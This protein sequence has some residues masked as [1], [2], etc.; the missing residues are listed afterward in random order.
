MKSLKNALGTVINKTVEGVVKAF[1]KLKKADRAAM[2]ELAGIIAIG[3]GVF[4]IAAPAGF[5]V[6]GLI[7]VGIGFVWDRGSA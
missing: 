7:A 1:L 3:Y 2:V 5:I 6:C 4:L